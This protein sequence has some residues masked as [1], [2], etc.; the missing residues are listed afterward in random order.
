MSLYFSCVCV[1]VF[2]GISWLFIETIREIEFWSNF[3]T[4]V[5]FLQT[6]FFAY[7]IY[8][9]TVR[10]EEVF[11]DVHFAA[12]KK[13]ITYAPWNGQEFLDAYFLPVL[14]VCEI[15]TSMAVVYMM[16]DK[17]SMIQENIDDYGAILTWIGNF[18]VHYLTLAFLLFY[19]HNKTSANQ[20]RSSVV[21]Q[22]IKN[23]PSPF[24]YYHT[25]SFAAFILIMTYVI[26]FDPNEHY[27]IRSLSKNDVAI[28]TVASSCFSLG[29][30]VVWSSENL[31]PPFEQKNSRSFFDK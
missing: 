11:V 9:N 25:I 15:T 29:V 14:F 30:F 7:Y 31:N 21:N 6:L 2:V 27:G 12:T 17:A 5:W 4:W 3:T 19:M 8:F 13:I 22:H 26:M 28:G 1:W 10:S 18:I 20:H 16:V 23:Q 24:Y